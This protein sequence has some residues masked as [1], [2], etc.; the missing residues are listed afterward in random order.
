MKIFVGTMYC[1]ENDYA[2]CVD[3]IKSQRLVAVEQVT[4]SNLPEHDA[5]NALW[6]EWR[7]RQNNYD[8]FVKVDADTVLK[9][10]MILHTIASLFLANSRLT[11]VQAPLHD[12]F[13]DSHINGL[14]C[15]SPKVIFRDTTDPLYCDR[16]DTGHDI[17]YREHDLPVELIPAGYHCSYASNVQAF[18]FG[19][20]RAL[21]N[22]RDTLVRVKNAWLNHNHDMS[23]GYVL[24]GAYYAHVFRNGGFNYADDLFRRTY[25]YVVMNLDDILKTVDD[26]S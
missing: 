26:H 21:K 5:H 6:K 19:V 3:A 12:F 17:A 22:Q 25:A 15:F 18:H 20:H 4:V 7:S 9:N 1:G 13:T 8:L 16:V 10:D 11:G 24:A 23:R 2:K 14:N